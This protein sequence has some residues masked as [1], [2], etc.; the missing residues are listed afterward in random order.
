MKLNESHLV[1]CRRDILREIKDFE[2]IAS[3]LD[4]DDLL[5]GLR[6]HF[7]YPPDITD[8]RTLKP[9]GNFRLERNHQTCF[10]RLQKNVYRSIL[11]STSK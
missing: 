3:D 4:E 10:L 9:T 6:R 2:E 11:L 1:E 5:F 7:G 8:L